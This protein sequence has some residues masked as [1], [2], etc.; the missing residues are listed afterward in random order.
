MSVRCK[1]CGAMAGYGHEIGHKS[2]CPSLIRNSVMRGEKSINNARTNHGL[3]AVSG[4]AESMTYDP[5]PLIGVIAKLD[6]KPTD[7]VVLKSSEPL[8]ME[9]VERFR[10]IWH[11]SIGLSNKI[12]F[13]ERMDI[14]VLSPTSE[15]IP[16]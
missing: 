2:D 12:V 5:L 11:E 8:S 4:L 7:I 16:S 10:R 14:E 1:D 15:A 6:L 9:A 3:P 13:L